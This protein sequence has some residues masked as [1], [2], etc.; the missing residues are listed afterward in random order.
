MAGNNQ[1][2]T[3]AQGALK[4]PLA[5][6]ITHP[7]SKTDASKDPEPT[8][9]VG[10]GVTAFELSS[11]KEMTEK[12][13]KELPDFKAP[14]AP[15]PDVTSDGKPQLKAFYVNFTT[16]EL[17]L[18][19]STPDNF[20]AFIMTVK[21]FNTLYPKGK[22]Y[23]THDD[24]QT[25]LSTVELN[26]IVQAISESIGLYKSD[27]GKSNLDYTKSM[28]AR[29]YLNYITLK[30]KGR[31]INLLR[32]EKLPNMEQFM[33]QI[34]L[35][36]IMKGKEKTLSYD[37]CR[38]WFQIL[39]RLMDFDLQG[40]TFKTEVC[41]NFVE[42]F[43]KAEIIKE[44]LQ[45][46]LKSNRIKMINLNTFNN[47]IYPHESDYIDMLGIET[48]EKYEMFFAKMKARYDKGDYLCC[49]EIHKY[50]QAVR[51]HISDDGLGILFKR[52]SLR[53]KLAA[54]KEVE[55]EA[56]KQKVDKF[57]LPLYYYISKVKKD[58]RKYFRPLGFTLAAD[59]ILTVDETAKTKTLW[60]V[61]RSGMTRQSET[62]KISLDEE[63]LKIL[64]KKLIDSA[65]SNDK[66]DSDGDPIKYNAE[67]CKEIFDRQVTVCR[68]A[69]NSMEEIYSTMGTVEDTIF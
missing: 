66:K 44:L 47:V 17:I 61:T 16:E 28:L 53:N 42:N 37:Y 12:L 32:D 18:P 20:S 11:L 68:D 24:R 5:S 29:F 22:V 4:A 55:L 67:F 15:A 38:L 13:F 6:I 58:E 50:N 60:R 39:S 3:S 1:G 26:N 64:L 21:L 30:Y 31:F 46:A 54:T 19:E 59:G 34:G 14:V 52:L 27:G 63:R 48:P 69:T 8:V 43:K 23:V 57:K 7:V 49:T 9:K 62:V 10:Q 56:K 51:N 45:D 2:Q 33:R 40:G 41:N 35:Q 65:F 25:G 36:P